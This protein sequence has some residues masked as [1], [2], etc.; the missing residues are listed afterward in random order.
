MLALALFKAAKRQKSI[1]NQWRLF[2]AMPA[3][4]DPALDTSEQSP[5]LKYGSLVPRATNYI[6]I[7]STLPQPKV[8]H[9]FINYFFN[10]NF[11]RLLFCQM[12]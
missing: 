12:G 9:H 1:L 3:V 6:P 8:S 4:A 7:L 10:K 11:K 2:S 5:F